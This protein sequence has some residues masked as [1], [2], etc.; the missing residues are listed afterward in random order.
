[1]PVRLAWAGHV[2]RVGQVVIRVRAGYHR[3]HVEH[4]VAHGG[5]A[6]EPV[7]QAAARDDA[8]AIGA[9]HV[10][11]RRIEREHAVGRVAVDEDPDVAVVVGVVVDGVVGFTGGV[12]VLV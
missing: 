4:G 5:V 1:M 12:G 10:A 3:I 7:A 9:R 8:V 2:A 6:G 11:D